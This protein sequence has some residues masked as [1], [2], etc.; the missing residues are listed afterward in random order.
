MLQY[1]WQPMSGAVVKPT[2]QPT[3]EWRCCQTD[4]T[5]NLW[6]VLLSRRQNSQPMSGAVVKQTEQPTYEWCCCQTDRTANLWVVLLSSRQNSQSLEKQPN[7]GESRLNLKLGP[8][9]WLNVMTKTKPWTFRSQYKERETTVTLL[10]GQILFS[11]HPP[12][13]TVSSE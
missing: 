10:R 11:S 5:A 1:C 3:Y 12:F 9:P 8:S 13:K 7:K 2:E 4:R 6:V